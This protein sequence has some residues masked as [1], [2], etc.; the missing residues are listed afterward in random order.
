[1]GWVHEGPAVSVPFAVSGL[2]SPADGSESGG[3]ALNLVRKVWNR[4]NSD[5]CTNLAAQVSFY[6]ILSLFP[7]FL[8]L[9]SFLGW[10]PTTSKWDSFASWVT[11]YFP[12]QARNIVLTIMI[13][14][15]H[16]YAGFFSFG[17]L[18]TIWSAS[19]GFVSLME[20]LSIAYGTR[21][22][23]SYV[24]K[25]I[26][27]ILATVVAALFLIVCFG[28]WNLGHVMAVT[29]SNDLKFFVF[30]QMQ[31]RIIRWV[32]T[33]ILMSIGINLINHF[34]PDVKHPWHWFTPGTLVVAL[35]FIGA[36]GAFEIYLAHGSNMPTL[37]GA[38]A[39]FIVLMLWIYLANLVLLIG[40][41]TDTVWRELKA[42]GTS[43]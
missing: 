16:G 42:A 4:L 10:I 15:S 20:A 28:L 26:V 30:F 17:L 6:F 1:M 24:K 41:E 3:P 22:N 38:L 23:R 36:T 33:L 7:F 25:R 12:W 5:D 40:A 43:A 32:V 2:A 13:Q 8:V 39:G 9:A 37:Y 14:L 31:W 19:S 34:L 35:S 18:V 21:D 29:V 27:A 11:A